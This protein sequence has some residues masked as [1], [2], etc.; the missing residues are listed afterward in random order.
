MFTTVLQSS[1]RTEE[2]SS[3]TEDQAP[4]IIKS[5][6]GLSDVG[7]LNDAKLNQEVSSFFQSHI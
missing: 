2:E 5:A 7:I 1:E 6:E 3:A 4:K